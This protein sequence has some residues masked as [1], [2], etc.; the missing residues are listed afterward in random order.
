M[1]QEAA[2]AGAVELVKGKHDLAHLI[3]KVV[4]LDARP[5]YDLLDRRPS[6]ENAAA[7]AVTLRTDLEAWW[8]KALPT[9]AAEII[10]DL[11][12]GWA[13]KRRPGKLGPENTA[14]ALQILKGVV[15][16]LERSAANL[17][18]R[19]FSRRMTGSSKLIEENRERIAFYLCR[20]AG[21]PDHLERAEDVLL[22]FGLGKIPQPILVAGPLVLEGGCFGCDPYL[23]LAPETAERIRAGAAVRH[24]LTIENLTSFN[25]H[26][27]DARGPNEIVVYSGGFPGR[28]VLGFLQRLVR[29]TGAQCWHWGDIDLGGIRIAHHLHRN[30]PGGVRLHLMSEALARASGQPMAPVRDPG[31]PAE[32]PL[33]ALAAFLASF[34]ARSLEQ[35]E[36]DPEPIGAA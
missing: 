35:E 11:E 36:I 13:V 34:E 4:L 24:I 5:L 28:H 21:L 3:E 25:R 1:L 31:I 29:E 22:Y 2:A 20:T 6:A 8:G 12:R 33:A 16:I 9:Y 27:R 18:L 30:L 10:D 17:D 32:S 15:A 23:G 14:E 26:V 7:A 19:T